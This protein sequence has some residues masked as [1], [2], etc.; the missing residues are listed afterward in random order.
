MKKVFIGVGHGGRDPGAVGN[1]L[2]EKELSL[3]VAK[4][5]RDVLK[6]H[7]V[8]VLL[9]RETDV[10]ENL[11]QR[12]KECNA[13]GPDIAVDIHVN[14]GGGD[15]AEI[16]HSANKSYDDAL[17]KNI[18]DEIVKIGQNSRGLKTKL[19][20]NTD[21]FGFVRQIACPSVL[22]ESAFID[23]DDVKIIDTLPERKSMG[24]AIA[25]GILITLGIA[26]KEP[27]K[28]TPP[29]PTE[30]FFPPRGYFKKGD[31]SENVGKVASFM[32]KNFPAYTSEKA[33]GNIYGPYLIKSITEFQR[34]TGLV[35][36]GCTGPITLA[37]LKEHGFKF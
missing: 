8:N 7:G 2:K 5:C 30:S 10:T 36:D 15:G 11:S 14:A 34:R 29:K 27:T 16:F 20:G 24:K 28:P 33:L 19:Y 21:Y 17:A 6:A 23:S 31:K 35:P 37:K 18:L 13:F 1:G 4:A 3:D 26:Y 25:K 9:S 32:R 12:I 22:V